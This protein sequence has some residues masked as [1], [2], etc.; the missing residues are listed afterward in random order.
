M[1]TATLSKKAQ[2]EQE[3]E[4]AQD[5]LRRTFAEQEALGQR[6]TVWTNLKS[7]SASGMS[8]DMK[9]LTVKDGQIVDI[10]WYVAKA[11]SVGS[12]KERNGQRVIRVGGCGMDMGFHLVY[13]LSYSLYKSANGADTGYYLR[14][15]WI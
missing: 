5:F 3:K 8:R 1:T 6:P 11:C 9:A 15:E 2:A 7:V 10:T 13:S 4:Q 12:L 14:H